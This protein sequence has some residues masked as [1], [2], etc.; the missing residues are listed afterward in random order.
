MADNK[1]KKILLENATDKEL[2]AESLRRRNI[3][4]NAENMENYRLFLMDKQ[5][6]NALRYLNFSKTASGGVK[7]QGPTELKK[8]ELEKS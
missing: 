6:H 8:K 3:E 7:I 1:L 2:L 5:T 4:T